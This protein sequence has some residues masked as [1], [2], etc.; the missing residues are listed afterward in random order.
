MIVC[1]GCPKS[2]THA[3]MSL[4]AM[5]GASR[6]AGVLDGRPANGPKLVV[7]PTKA[8]PCVDSLKVNLAKPHGHYIHG[9]VPVHHWLDLTKA[10]VITIVRDPRNVLTSYLRAKKADLNPHNLKLAL[11]DFYGE[12][13]YSLYLSFLGWKN[14]GAIVRFENIPRDFAPPDP[15]YREAK[16]DHSTKTQ[17]A[18]DWSEWWCPETERLWNDAK[19]PALLKA[20]GYA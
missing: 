10:K 13:F 12:P 2:G 1:N 20:A 4:I 6:L 7:R 3:L 14:F 16:R 19:G 17:H 8:D 5:T 9:H 18:M 11:N 15:V